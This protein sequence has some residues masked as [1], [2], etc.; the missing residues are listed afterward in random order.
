GPTAEDV[1]AAQEM[2]NEARAQFIRTMVGR[3][4]SRLHED[5]SDVN[6]WL[7]LLRAYMVMGER[8]KAR[9]AAGEAREALAGE[10]E[11]LK[12][13]DAGLKNLGVG[14]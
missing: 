1:T 8:D 5:G 11:K 10:P 13:F 14:E 9:T 3:L 7:R 6:G 2:P 12:L 4:A